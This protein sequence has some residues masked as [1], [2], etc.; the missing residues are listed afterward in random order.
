MTTLQTTIDNNY[1]QLFSLISSDTEMLGYVSKNNFYRDQAYFGDTN[2]PDGIAILDPIVQPAEDG[3]GLQTFLLT[4]DI[5]FYTKQ[6]PHEQSRDILLKM[7]SRVNELLSLRTNRDLNSTC[8]YANVILSNPRPK[9]GLLVSGKTSR[10]MG[11]M[12]IQT[13]ISVELTS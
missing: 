12:K 13:H 4:Y 6:L 9:R 8:T 10:R 5:Y 1:D 11:E 3:F 2:W 7:M